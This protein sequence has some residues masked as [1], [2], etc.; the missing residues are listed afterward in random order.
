MKNKTI[1]WIAEN[2]WWVMIGCLAIPAGCLLLNWMI[3][4]A[5]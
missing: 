5:P 4:N 2:A 1:D 3:A